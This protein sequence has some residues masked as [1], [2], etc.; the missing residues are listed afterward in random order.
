MYSKTLSTAVVAS[1]FSAANAHFL[2]KNPSPIPGS[3]PKDPLDAS[4][5][6]FPCHGADLTQGSV[7]NL[8]VGQTYNLDFELGNGANTAVHGGGSCQLSV[9]YSTDATQLKDPANWKVI[10]SYVGGCPTNS[11]GN[12]PTAV[13]CPT[14]APDCVNQLNFTVPPEVQNGNAIFAWTWFNNIGNREMYMNCAKVSISGGQNQLN[15]LPAMQVANLASINQCGTTERFNLQ[16]P[17]PG[18]YVVNPSTLN[19]PLMPPTKCGASTSGSTGSTGSTG[20]GSSGSGSSGSGSSAATGGTGTSATSSAN[21]GQYTGIGASSASATA[22]K[23][24]AS[25]TGGVF[26]PG[27]SSAAAAQPTTLATSVATAA[28]GGS[29]ATASAASSPAASGSTAGAISG[30][31]QNG[32][33]ACTASGFYCIDAQH[34]GE[35]AFGCAVPMAMAAGTTCTNNAVAAIV[36]PG[37][38]FRPRGVRRHAHKRHIGDSY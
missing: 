17:N 27:A 31:C 2:I 8:Q 7:T 10:T 5:A 13:M 6:N 29:S 26:A 23:A 38:S 37:K 35:C 22:P 28:A 4:G 25:N 12:L 1:L 18:K 21:N 14:S 36:V 30:N 3:A 24:S 15:S 16:F 19:Y 20:S 33:V 32:A 9:A 34:Y 11:M